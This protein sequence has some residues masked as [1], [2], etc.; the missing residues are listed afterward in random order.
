MTE[1]SEGQ[2]TGAEA[3]ELG[4]QEGKPASQIE[5]ER[6]AAEQSEQER[7]ERESRTPGGVNEVPS[8]P[9]DSEAERRAGGPPEPV[10]GPEDGQG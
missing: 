2:V 6:L 8:D 5:G 1:Q 7:L 3:E 4:R 9:R 10:R